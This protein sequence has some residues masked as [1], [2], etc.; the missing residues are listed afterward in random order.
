MT[1]DIPAA[2]PA[3][4]AVANGEPRDGV[5]RN[6]ARV[7]T[8]FA[9][10]AAAGTILSGWHLVGS[11]SG[12]ILLLLGWAAVMTSVIAGFGI[13]TVVFVRRVGQRIEAGQNRNAQ[14]IVARL[15]ERE[16]IAD[17]LEEFHQAHH[18]LRDAVFA[19]EAMGAGPKKIQQIVEDSLRH[20]AKGMTVAVGVPC[21]ATIKTASPPK[22]VSLSN[23]RQNDYLVSNYARSEQRDTHQRRAG[24]DNT[25]GANS[26]FRFLMDRNATVRRCWWSNDLLALSAYDNPHWPENPRPDNVPYRAAMVWPIRYI[27]NPATHTEPADIYQVGF[28]AVD[29]AVVDV[30]D[31]DKH[32]PLGAAYAD[33][34][35]ATI[36]SIDDAVAAVEGNTIPGP[37]V[38]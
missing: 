27:I 6:L 9:L 25:I 17:S 8:V 11:N 20:F 22:D 21:H 14:A 2:A 37:A 26:D 12:R 28:L 15:A 38:G 29:C 16:R 4:G 1:S 33:H 18:L 32:F 5:W 3:D 13:A 7:D 19:K 36:W 10:A 24:M 35:L 30:F 23:T 31:L 34:L